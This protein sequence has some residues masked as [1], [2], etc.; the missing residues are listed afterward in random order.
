MRYSKE[1]KIYWVK[2]RVK[3]FGYYEIA[4]KFKN[5][6]QLQKK[7]DP[8]TIKALVKKFERSKSVKNIYVNNRKL[9]KDLELNVLAYVE[10][11]IL[12]FN[13]DLAHFSKNHLG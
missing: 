4:T 5:N 3:G 12:H 11:K 2:L 13:C 10:V 6:F 9:S 7:P 1:D 8:K